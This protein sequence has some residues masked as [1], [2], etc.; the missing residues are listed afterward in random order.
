MSNG[1]FHYKNIF[2]VKKFYSWLTGLHLAVLNFVQLAIWAKFKTEK[3]C[4]PVKAQI[5]ETYSFR[6]LKKTMIDIG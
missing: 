3:K 4:G 5:L 6:Y 1:I 2:V